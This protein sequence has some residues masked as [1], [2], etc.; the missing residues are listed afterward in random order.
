MSNSR[1]HYDILG[2]ASNADQK[3]I[4][5]AYLRASLNCHPD[6]NPG[7]EA[8]A[9]A[10]FI[11]IGEAYNILKDPVSRASYDRELA[12]GRGRER[13]RQRNNHCTT[14]AKKEKQFE[15]FM[16][17]F[18]STVAGM[19]QEELH[20]AVGAAAVVGSVIGSIL[21]SRATKGNSFL[22][23]AV[24]TVGSAM[25]SQAAATL[26]KTLHEDSTQRVLQ[27]EERAAAIARGEPVTQHSATQNRERL[28]QDA[29]GVVQKMAAAAA[30]CAMP[31]SQN[32]SSSQGSQFRANPLYANNGTSRFSFSSGTK[33]NSAR[34]YR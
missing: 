5:Q 16:E 23:S 19:S 10:K 6:K 17:M 1:S 11:E 3:G 31:S 2:V 29:I 20:M 32:M 33:P 7:N 21:S 12:A 28:F 13:R 9:K 30:S 8:A 15:S 26:V 14:E 25:A 34:R 18:D 22:A 27:R 4:R 24:S